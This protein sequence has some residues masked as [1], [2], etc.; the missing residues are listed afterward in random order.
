M[1]NSAPAAAWLRHLLGFVSLSKPARLWGNR[2][3]LDP[4]AASLAA[5]EDF[6]GKNVTAKRP[7]TDGPLE[8]RRF[9]VALSFPG[10][11]RDYVKEVVD[12]LTAE[13]GD[14]AIFYDEF[15]SAEL[16][17]PNLD[18]LL[19]AVYHRNSLLIVACLCAEYDH[20]EWC[21]LEWRAIRDLIKKRHDNSI[22]LIRFDEAEVD[23]SFSIDGYVDARRFSPLEC[24]ALVAKRARA[25]EAADPNGN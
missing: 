3:Q 13:F 23:G 17:R 10:E 7:G 21:G 24:A 18:T 19:Q 9:K 12:Y 6:V 14:E 8:S 4:F 15:Y 5:L 1:Q 16:A 2:L 20:K 11:K 25:L 22:M